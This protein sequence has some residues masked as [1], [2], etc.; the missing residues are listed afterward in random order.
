MPLAQG[1]RQR[2]LNQISP[3]LPDQGGLRAG[4]RRGR[5][6]HGLAGLDDA[7]LAGRP[8]TQPGAADQVIDRDKPTQVR[9]E[10]IGSVIAKYEV[11]AI[12]HGD[13]LVVGRELVCRRII[14]VRLVN[15]LSIDENVS[16]VDQN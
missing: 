4:P 12:R 7:G 2:G 11:V 5:G 14:N 10:A 3:C 6:L 9:V 8:V 1:S 13:R 16:L 15:A